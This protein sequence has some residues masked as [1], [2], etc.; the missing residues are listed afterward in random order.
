MPRYIGMMPGARSGRRFSTGPS[1]VMAAWRTCLYECTDKSTNAA[2]KS[3]RGSRQSGGMQG[4]AC[5]SVSALIG[6]VWSQAWQR[7]HGL[8]MQL[9]QQPWLQS[10]LCTAI[11]SCHAMLMPDTQ[12]SDVGKVQPVTSTGC[13][14][15]LQDSKLQLDCHLT[16]TLVSA[17]TPAGGKCRQSGASQGRK[18]ACE[19]RHVA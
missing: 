10:M 18:A 6:Q 19:A 11:L 1:W 16:R 14:Q 12:D 4:S 15:L 7:T 2:S 9:C 5:F 8:G 3:C 13:D 17:S